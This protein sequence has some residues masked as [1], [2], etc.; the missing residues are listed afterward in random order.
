[1]HVGANLKVLKGLSNS[2]ASS[3]QSVG[4]KANMNNLLMQLRK[5]DQALPLLSFLLKIIAKMC[6]ASLS[7]GRKY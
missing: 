2:T 3:K 1:M 6:S 4:A 7:H 5:C